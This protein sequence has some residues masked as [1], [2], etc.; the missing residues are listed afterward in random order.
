MKRKMRLQWRRQ[1]SVGGQGLDSLCGLTMAKLLG[2]ILSIRKPWIFY[3][4]VLYQSALTCHFTDAV[5]VPS[6]ARIV[7]QGEDM[8]I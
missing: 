4:S 6:Q 1:R 5:L 7:F 3:A 8:T 2:F